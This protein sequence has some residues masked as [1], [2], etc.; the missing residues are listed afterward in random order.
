ME[1][2]WDLKENALIVW[3][4]QDT[5]SVLVLLNFFYLFIYFYF[6]NFN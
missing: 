3:Y 4:F 1:L 6:P 5:Q 2:F